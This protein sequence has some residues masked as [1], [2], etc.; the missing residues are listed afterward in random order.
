MDFDAVMLLSFGGPDGPDDVMPFLA[1]V[2]RGRPVPPERVQE[3]AAHYMRFGGRSPINGQNRALIEALA[4]EFAE[5]GRPRPIYWGNRNW[6]PYVAEA[7]AAMRS[8][9]VQRA[10]VFVTSAYSSYSGCRQYI[11][12]LERAR[13]EV[14]AGAPELVKIRPFFDHPGFIAAL[15][16][17]LSA[18]VAEAGA[19]VPVLMSAH[20]IP[21][22]SAATCRYE[23]QLRTTARLVAEAAG[24]AEWQMVFQSRSGA[25]SHPWLGPDVIEAIAGLGSSTS[26]VIVCPIGFVSDHMEVVYD[27]D[28]QAQEAAAA[29]GVRLHRSATPGTH[30]RFV[31][32]VCELLDELERG[33][34]GDPGLCSAGCC[35][36]PAARPTP[37]DSTR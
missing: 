1:N 29:T 12:D 26:D 22:A 25:P 19:D 21:T 10:A 36:P 37:V 14:G 31:H 2:L 16:D 35:P 27:L 17:G 24:V 33:E 23:D 18:S 8:D 15:A 3:V 34:P 9:G 4:A 5:H 11:E 6:S 30:P 7:V 32:M 20:S 13:R 28:T